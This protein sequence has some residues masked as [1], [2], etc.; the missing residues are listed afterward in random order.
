MAETPRLGVIGIVV[1]LA[2]IAARLVLAGPP[3]TG[4]GKAVTAAQEQRTA[5]VSCRAA[6][7]RRL[8]NVHLE[9]AAGDAITAEGGCTLVIRNSTIVAPGWGIVVQGGAEITIEHSTIQGGTGSLSIEDGGEVTIQGS[10]F[11]G[12]IAKRPEGQLT[13]KGGNTLP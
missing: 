13:N 5:K 9:V 2:G 6:S 10:T 7:E 11:K 1:T 4:T 12:R 3:Q 8:E